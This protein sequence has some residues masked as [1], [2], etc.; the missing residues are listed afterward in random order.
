[1]SKQP[2]THVKNH[3]E[4]N[5]HKDVKTAAAKIL[6]QFLGGVH[7]NFLKSSPSAG[8]VLAGCGMRTY[9]TFPMPGIFIIGA[10]LILFFSPVI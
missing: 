5:P 2:F 9:A 1:M 3:Q 10:N 6:N 7:K 4:A 8:Y